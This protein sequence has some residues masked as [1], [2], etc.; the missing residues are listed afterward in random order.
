VALGWDTAPPCIQH[1]IA[2][3]EGVYK[4]Y[5][6]CADFFTLGPGSKLG[7]LGGG[8]ANSYYALVAVGFVVMLAFLVAWVVLEDRKLKRQAAHLLVAGQAGQVALRA[9]VPQPGLGGP[10]SS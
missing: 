1:G 4:P 8:T 10:A 3:S 2:G 6:K 9:D 7:T 5:E